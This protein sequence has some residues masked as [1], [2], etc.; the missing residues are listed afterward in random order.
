MRD[1]HQFIIHRDKTPL[2]PHTLQPGNPHDPANWMDYPAASALADVY[3]LEIGFSIT[4]DDPFFFVDIDHCLENGQWSPLAVQ[5]CRQL[6]GCYIE[7]SRSGQGLH[8]IGSCP[9]PPTHRSKNVPL[10][11]ELY[12]SGRYVALTGNRAVGSPAHHAQLGPVIAAYFAPKEEAGLC[13][14]WSDG[15]CPEWSGPVDDTELLGRMLRSQSTAAAFGS[16]ATVSDLWAANVDTLARVFP[17]KSDGKEFDYSSADQALCNHLAWWTGK[18][19]GRMD[20][21]FRMSALCRDK[22]LDREDY[23]RS[24]I[25]AACRACKEVYGQAAKVRADEME[26]AAATD[27][28]YRTGPQLLTIPQQV[29]VFKGCVYVRDAHR[30]FTPD[31]A[32]LKPD[33]FRAAYGGYRFYIDADHKTTVKNAWEAFT[34]S[35]GYSH[36]KVH[37]TC[38]RPELAAGAMI[39]EEGIMMVNTYVPIDVPRKAGD[40]G[41]ILDLIEKILPVAEDRR[42]LLTYM[43]ACVQFP[44]RK[45]QWWPLVQGVQGNGKS[46]LAHCVA[47]AIG[48]RYTHTPNAGDLGNKFNAWLLGKLWIIVE[49][50][51]VGEKKEVL[52]A[53]KPL[54]TNLKIEIQGKG[55]NQKTGDNRANG[56]LLSNW[57]TAI[58]LAS[59]DRRY[60][61]FF[62]AQQEKDDLIRDGLTGRYFNSLWDWCREEGFAIMAEYLRSYPV[63]DDDM[64][65]LM[66]R[67]PETSSTAE[68]IAACRGGL[69]QEIEEAISEGR[70]G[71]CGGWI[72]SLALDALINSRRNGGRIPRNARR[73][74]LRELGYDPHPGLPG[75]R[76]NTVVLIDGGKPVLYIAK[77]HTSL[78]LPNPPA[79]VAAYTQA[80][81]QT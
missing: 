11:I 63:T 25:L 46:L 42:K 5:L 50:V 36:P 17:P 4:E 22:W 44:G 19:C 2:S 13:A 75:G 60:C 58:R 69:E 57:K 10:G 48:W 16:R 56:I 9:D 34:E 72:S 68:A 24:T 37:A 31:G 1:Y 40:P 74:I 49:E 76:S 23:R 70:P 6:A 80:Q 64:T 77:G 35:Q 59:R 78:G 71:F 39:S 12:T 7:V 8:I 61:V 45:F 51:C 55:D 67:A 41:R 33:Q 73:E 66:Y 32:L 21:L 62:C 54:I 29:G 15:P 79:I 28:A 3:G 30:V 81:S 27:S 38:F 65:Q 18:D 43:A 53:L 47:H 14:E 20:R 52:E 26:L